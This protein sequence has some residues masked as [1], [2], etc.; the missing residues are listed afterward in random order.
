MLGDF[1]IIHM[2][3]NIRICHAA[4]QVCLK[5]YFNLETFLLSLHPGQFF[6]LLVSPCNGSFLFGFSCSS[7]AFVTTPSPVIIVT[8]YVR[9]L[10]YDS[11]CC[12]VKFSLWICGPDI[13][14]LCVLYITPLMLIQ[15]MLWVRRYYPFIIH[16]FIDLP[17]EE[18]CYR[19]GNKSFIRGM[20]CNKTKTFFLSWKLLNSRTPKSCSFLQFK[21]HHFWREP[22]LI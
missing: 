13:V 15:S 19:S 9:N 22:S 12:Q 1:Q 4:F 21:D 16:L 20:E 10:I 17:W 6:W 8:L 18:S 14:R 7:P 11:Y 3:P 5:P 2:I